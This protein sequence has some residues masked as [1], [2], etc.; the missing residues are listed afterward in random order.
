MAYYRIKR[1]HFFI[2]MKKKSWD[3]EEGRKKTETLII[4]AKPENQKTPLR[5][6][7]LFCGMRFIKIRWDRSWDSFYRP[8]LVFFLIF[9]K[10]KCVVQTNPEIKYAQPISSALFSYGYQ[11]VLIKDCCAQVQTSYVTNPEI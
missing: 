9:A 5:C 8:I 10:F 2:I 3:L 11:T 7:F 1:K 6:F 4:V